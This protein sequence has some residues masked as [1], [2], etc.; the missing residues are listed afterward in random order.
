MDRD[1]LKALG[2]FIFFGTVAFVIGII[3]SREIAEFGLWIIPAFGHIYPLAIFSLVL[4][5]SII[6]SRPILWLHLFLLI[7]IGLLSECILFRLTKLFVFK[8]PK[9]L[10]FFLFSQLMLVYGVTLFLYFYIIFRITSKKE[11]EE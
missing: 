1:I 5:Y 7:I 11:T 10:A 9:I 2:L 3:I 4:I 8:S 6:T